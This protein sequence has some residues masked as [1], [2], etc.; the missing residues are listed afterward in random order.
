MFY[1]E[2]CFA[3]FLSF[4]FYPYTQPHCLK[5]CCISVVKHPPLE[6]SIHFYPTITVYRKV[7]YVFET[8][9]TETFSIHFFSIPWYET[10]VW[11][12]RW[13]SI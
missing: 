13:I 10:Q 1:H 8:P 3:T 12:E 7:S 2:N 9:S 5:K 6:R 4:A 11:L